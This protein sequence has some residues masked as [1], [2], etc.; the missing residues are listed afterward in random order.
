MRQFLIAVLL[1]LIPGA[2]AQ[3]EPSVRIGLNQNAATVT[4]R[5]ASAFSV[6]QY[7]TR[8]AT[9]TS[10]LT[11]GNGAAA[12]ILKKPDL[13]YRMV[14]GLEGGMLLAL[15]PGTKMWMAS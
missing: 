7:R 15:S 4:I 6:Q 8:S 12:A 10:V 1:L 3:N 14:V 9:V 11:L 2:Q 5:S 13:R